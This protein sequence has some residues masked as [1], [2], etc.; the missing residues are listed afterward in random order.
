M[1][2]ASRPSLARWAASTLANTLII[3]LCAISSSFRFGPMGFVPL[4]R[5]HAVPTCHPYAPINGVG[6][7]FDSDT[8]IE[9]WTRCDGAERWPVPRSDHD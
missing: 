7:P 5:R 9:L 8:A 4:S 1:P 3:S 2:A 6:F